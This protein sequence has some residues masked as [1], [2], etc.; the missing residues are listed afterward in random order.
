VPQVG[1]QADALR[2]QPLCS[3]CISAPLTSRAERRRRSEVMVLFSS[4]ISSWEGS[5]CKAKCARKIRF[6]YTRRVTAGLILGTGLKQ[7]SDARRP[8][9]ILDAIGWF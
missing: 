6:L 4:L 5:V 8:S 1:P 9:T 2:P 3:L 7:L